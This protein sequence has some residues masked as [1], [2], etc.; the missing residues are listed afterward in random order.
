MPQVPLS[1]PLPQ[2]G[3]LLPQSPQPPVQDLP[4][5]GVKIRLVP[6]PDQVLKVLLPL[7]GVGSRIARVFPG[8]SRFLR[9]RKQLQPIRFPNICSFPW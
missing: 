9:L 4:Y 7:P 5:P 3:H 6:S 2:L 8:L 1:L